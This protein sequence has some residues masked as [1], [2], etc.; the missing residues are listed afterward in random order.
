MEP[1]VTVVTTLYNYA[2]Y[3]QETMQSFLS[4]DMEESEMVIVDD[5]SSDSWRDVVYPISSKSKNR[6]RIVE[7]GKNFG[8]SSAKNAGIFFAKSP[9]LVMLDADD[10]LA[11]DGIST[12]FHVMNK[13]NYDM[14]HAPALRL[15]KKKE[16]MPDFYSAAE[17]SKAAKKSDGYKLI[18]AQGVMIKKDAHNLVGMYD[19]EMRCSSD[20]EMWARCIGRL[21]IGFSDSPCAIY[22]IHPEQMHSSKWKND[23]IDT[24]RRDTKSRI[25]RRKSSL[26]DVVMLNDYKLPH[27]VKEISI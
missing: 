26:D 27:G 22:R 15:G 18:H 3:I 8:Y 2:N 21:R 20:K 11:K 6:I 14:V 5:G 1:K 25:F 10:M 24:I 19:Q 7:M 12:R 17:R 23:N 9:V 16:I 4:Q 13:K